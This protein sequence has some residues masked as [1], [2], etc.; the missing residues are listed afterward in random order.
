MPNYSDMNSKE[1]SNKNKQNVQRIFNLSIVEQGIVYP[2]P[3]EMVRDAKL[4]KN[5]LFEYGT[6]TKIMELHQSGTSSLLKPV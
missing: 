1:E 5:F 2:H 6:H 3:I 4:K